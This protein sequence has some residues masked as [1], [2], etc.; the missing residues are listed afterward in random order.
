MMTNYQNSYGNYIA[1]V[2]GNVYLDVY[3][4]IA[5]IPVGYS[6]PSLLLAATSPDM[7]SAL[8]N[9]PAMGNFPQHD[10]AHIL[11][12]GMLKVAPKGMNQV[13]T[14]LAGSDANELA[15]KAAFM[16]KRRIQ[17]GGYVNRWV[18]GSSEGLDSEASDVSE[19]KTESKLAEYL[20][21]SFGAAVPPEISPA[22]P[23]H[24]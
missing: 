10:W 21:S 8:I 6:N 16:W 17:R 24:I 11:E 12:T 1:D 23:S 3:A 13:F 2:D 14:A 7:A 9:R 15:Y 22:I 18:S 20:R 19:R 4:Q 5:S